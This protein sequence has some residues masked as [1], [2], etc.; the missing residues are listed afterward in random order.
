V[1]GRV[2]FDCC[3]ICALLASDVDF[4]SERLRFA[5][6]VRLIF[7]TD[8]KRLLAVI[9]KRKYRIAIVHARVLGRRNLFGTM[10]VD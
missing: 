5:G 6:T 1:A 4:S 8:I 10:V 9:Q 2:A 3:T 7:W